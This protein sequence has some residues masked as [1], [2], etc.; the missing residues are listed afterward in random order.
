MVK[1]SVYSEHFLDSSLFYVRKAINLADILGRLY[2]KSDLLLQASELYS[3]KGAYQQAYD[4]HQKY[5]QLNDSLFNLKEQLSPGS[6]TL[7]LNDAIYLEHETTYSLPAE[8]MD[9]KFF[10][11]RFLVFGFGGLVVCVVALLIWFVSGYKTQRKSREKIKVLMKEIKMLSEEI[12]TKEDIINN[13]QRAPDHQDFDKQE[14]ILFRESESIDKSN[15]TL[16]TIRKEFY[17]NAIILFLNDQFEKLKKVQKELI[18]FT[19]LFLLTDISKEK[20]EPVNVDSLLKS[21]I[22]LKSTSTKERISIHYQP[23]PVLNLPCH[24]ASILLM[25]HCLLQNAIESIDD[26]GDIFLDC[27]SDSTKIT[28]KLMDNGRGIPTDDQNKIF[29]P[30]FSTKKSDHHLGLGL[31]VSLEIIKKHEAVIS[32]RSKPGIGTEVIIDFYYE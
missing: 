29:E 26:R 18:G 17:E 6:L 31:T 28:L 10:Q 14:Q 27:I 7:S 2:L 15:E 13:I 32:M 24:K 22:N 20:F 1:N 4:S 23:D 12:A 21:L 9:N 16:E 5:S 8:N 25:M 30:F 19:E 11:Y 3:K